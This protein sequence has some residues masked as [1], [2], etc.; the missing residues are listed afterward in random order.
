MPDETTAACA[1][2]TACATR[3]L[4]L[5]DLR[6]HRQLPGAHDLLDRC[7]LRVTD[8]R[9]R[10]PDRIG[11]LRR[12]L[13]VPRDRPLEPLVELDL[14]LEA[15]ELA[16]LV[17]VRDAQLDVR[18]VERLEHE[19]ARTPAEALDALGEVVDRHGRARVA[20]V[21]ALP[22]RVRV[23]ERE[24]ERLHHVVDVAPGADLR[25]VAVDHEVASRR[26]PSR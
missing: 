7:E 5:L 22:D 11:H 13:A 6:A 8:V 24:H 10:E 14:R 21:E 1:V 20:D 9:P 23:L 4:E 15:E 2:P 18:V 19:L 25:A 26:A 3:G 17:D 12:V 16:R